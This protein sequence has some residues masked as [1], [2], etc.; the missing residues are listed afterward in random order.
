MVEGKNGKA[1]QNW[2]EVASLCPGLIS[3]FWKTN[4]P[5]KTWEYKGMCVYMLK[6]IIFSWKKTTL[7]SITLVIIIIIII[8]LKLY[9]IP[10]KYS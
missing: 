1:M 2:K 4:M 3:T 10:I 6:R 9:K 8:A 7:K 5:P